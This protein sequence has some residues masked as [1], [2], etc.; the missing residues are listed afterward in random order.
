MRD[1]LTTISSMI[2]ILFCLSLFFV[3]GEVE[4]GLEQKEDRTDQYVRNQSGRQSVNDSLIFKR[5]QSVKLEQ[6]VLKFVTLE[7]EKLKEHY[8]QINGKNVIF[9]RDAESDMP[10]HSI[11]F[12]DKGS[13]TL[14]VT[15]PP[16]LEIDIMESLRSN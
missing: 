8:F 12:S 3:G 7:N 1:M 5:V 13:D 16:S 2:V 10:L 14:L 11:K 15:I 4:S 6:G 9:T